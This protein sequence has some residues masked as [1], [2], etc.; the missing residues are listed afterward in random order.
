MPGFIPP[1]EVAGAEGAL[2]KESLV[3][4]EG[5]P[6]LAECPALRGTGFNRD[7][8]RRRRPLGHSARRKLPRKLVVSRT[9]VSAQ[10]VQDLEMDLPKCKVIASEK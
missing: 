4:N 1:Q 5:M 9:S 10:G 2:L 6:H 7:I 3:R 8:R